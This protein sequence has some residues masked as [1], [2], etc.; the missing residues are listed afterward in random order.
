M[1]L[2]SLSIIHLCAYKTNAGFLGDVLLER[3]F[4]LEIRTDALLKDWLHSGRV[5]CNCGRSLAVHT[6]SKE[7]SGLKK[8]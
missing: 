5:F 1:P 8:P 4:V 6:N 3:I 2:D 7:F